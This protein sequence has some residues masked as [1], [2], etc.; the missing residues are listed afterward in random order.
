MRQGSSI[1]LLPHAAHQAGFSSSTSPTRFPP[2]EREC[3]VKTL[4]RRGGADEIEGRRR[5]EKESERAGEKRRGAAGGTRVE[6]NVLVTKY[7]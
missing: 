4:L 2:I 5:G 3:G 1:S 6:T 7:L